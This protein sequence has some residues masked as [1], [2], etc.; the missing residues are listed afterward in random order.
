[1]NYYYSRPAADQL[2]DDDSSGNA[3]LLRALTAEQQQHLAERLSA[4]LVK[5]VSRD[6]DSTTALPSLLQPPADDP[7]EEE[8]LEARLTRVAA[9]FAPA[10]ADA[11]KR[12]Q[13]WFDEQSAKL[14]FAVASCT[15]GMGLAGEDAP[16][17][18]PPKP[19]RQRRP[20]NGKM[21]TGVDDP[22]LEAVRLQLGI[23]RDLATRLSRLLV[24]PPPQW[25]VPPPSPPPQPH[26]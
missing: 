21:R 12:G 20:Q 23:R 16:P 17:P 6:V 9:E 13:Q 7:D 11:Q 15:H 19:R 5:E 1:M 18:Q 14:S 4:R 2:L 10:T 3:A 8:S 24:L 22:L 26:R 25:V